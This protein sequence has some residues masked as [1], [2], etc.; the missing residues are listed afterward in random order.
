MNG[1]VAA[2]EIKTTLT[3]VKFTMFFSFASEVSCFSRYFC[4]QRLSSF[5]RKKLSMKRNTLAGKGFLELFT[6]H[7]MKMFLFSFR[8]R[9]SVLKR[10]FPNNFPFAQ[11]SSP[12]P[13]PKRRCIV[14]SEKMRSF[15]KTPF[16][17]GAVDSQRRMFTSIFHS[18]FFDNMYQFV[19]S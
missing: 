12:N 7:R 5:S 11:P 3:I 1:A 8:S 15:Q 2:S 13:P 4:F 6:L 10:K 9:R 18:T 14:T 19:I 16:F 17:Q